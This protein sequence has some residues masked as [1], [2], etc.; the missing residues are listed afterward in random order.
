MKLP[1]A[2]KKIADG[3]EETLSYCDFPSE[4]CTRI[5]TNNVIERLIWEIRRR[6]RVVGCFPD[7]NS[8]LMLI[9]AQLR[10]VVGIQWGNKKYMIMKHLEAIKPAS[11]AG[12]L[13]SSELQT[14]FVRLSLLY[15]L[16]ML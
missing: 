15:R 3:N 12:W 10:H 6:T 4:H 9:C 2:A 14:K 16:S 11:L 7:G 8:A 1:K 13:Y 5:R